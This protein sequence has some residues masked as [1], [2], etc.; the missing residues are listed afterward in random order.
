M[1]DFVSL[2]TNTGIY[3]CKLRIYISAGLSLKFGLLTIS[4][5]VHNPE[6]EKDCFR[7]SVKAMYSFMLK[8]YIS[9]NTYAEIVSI[10]NENCVGDILSSYTRRH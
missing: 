5:L 2:K 6:K 4:H 3:I 1:Y 7:F 9:S 8:I 10:K